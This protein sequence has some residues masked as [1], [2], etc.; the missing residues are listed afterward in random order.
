MS[1]QNNRMR[2][3]YAGSTPE[4]EVKIKGLEGDFFFYGKGMQSKCI[5][6]CKAFTDYIGRTYGESERQSI[7]AN[8]LIM[9]NMDE[10]KDIETEEDFKKMTFKEQKMWEKQADVWF[11]ST[12]VINKNLSKAYSVLWSIC[13]SGLQQKIKSDK[14]FQVMKEGDV[15]ELFH[16]VQKICHGNSSTDNPYVNIVEASYNLLMIKGD[17]YPALSLYYEAFEKKFEVLEKCGFAVT[18][19]EFRDLYMKE[20]A[21]RNKESSGMYRLLEEW[22]IEDNWISKA[23]GEAAPKSARIAAQHA[24]ME[25]FKAHIY[26]K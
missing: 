17:S 26:I 25:Q 16:I 7:E 6:S 5:S 11:K 21:S 24:L 3:P 22:E 9:T 2:S 19:H 15:G 10:P 8:K 14:D 20:L 13:H 4:M 23:K 12:A 1:D 18:S